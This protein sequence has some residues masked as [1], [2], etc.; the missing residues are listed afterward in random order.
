MQQEALV[1]AWGDAGVAEHCCA[2]WLLD[3]LAVHGRGEGDGQVWELL[4]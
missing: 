1:A 3:L 4:E 2:A